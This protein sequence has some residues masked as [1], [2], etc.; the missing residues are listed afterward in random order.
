MQG[1]CQECANLVYEEETE[2][3]VCDVDMDE[4]DLVRYL[5]SPNASCPYYQNGDEYQIVKKQM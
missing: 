2:E 5:T 3:W 1:S 4:D